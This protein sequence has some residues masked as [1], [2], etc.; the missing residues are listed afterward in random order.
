LGFGWG[1]I[2]SLPDIIHLFGDTGFVNVTLTAAFHGCDSS[3]GQSNV[4][5]IEGPVASFTASPYLICSVPATVNFNNMSI[6]DDT[7]SWNFGDGTTSNLQNPPPHVYTTTGNKTI[8]LHVMSNSTSCNYTSTYTVL[9]PARNL[10]FTTDQS[11]V[12]ENVPVAFT[13]NTIATSGIYQWKWDFGDGFSTAFSFGNLP[14]M[15]NTTGTYN[16]PVHTYT[17]SGVYDVMLVTEDFSGCIDTLITSN[18]V[19]VKPLPIPDFA[20]DTSYGCAPILINFTNQS[21]ALGIITQWDWT[22]GDG[23]SSNAPNPSNYYTSPDDYDVTLAVTDNN[24][25]SATICMVNSID[26]TYPFPSFTCMS[27]VCDSSAVVFNN[28][29]VGSGMTFTW[30]FGDGTSNSNT[31]NPS[32]LFDA[33]TDVTTV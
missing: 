21:T 3:L 25:C 7:W 28:T 19:D 14:S 23:Q 12:C 20:M 33:L 22:F 6:M 32:H 18:I 16:A 30:D 2:D 17:A 31:T 13:D 4:V 24:N 1:D 8:S 10:A 29:S 27:V 9:I 5:Y 15:N 26:V 11:S